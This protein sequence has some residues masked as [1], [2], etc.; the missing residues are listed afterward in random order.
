ML[1]RRAEQDPGLVGEQVLGAVAVM[2]VEVHDGDALDPVG[3]QGVG[4]ADGDIAEETE[5]HRA[6]ALGVVA[7]RPHRAERALDVLPKDEVHRVDECARGAQGRG[8]RVRAHDGVGV[9]A[10]QRRGRRG[11]QQTIDVRCVVD[12]DE[13]LARDLRGLDGA[14]CIRDAGL[15]HV[16]ADRGEP[17]R[18]LGVTGPG[19]VSVAERMREPRACH[20]V[21]SVTQRSARVRSLSPA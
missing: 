14:P 2:H 6:A 9:E 4:R 11:T 7:G 12:S 18:S 8:Q 19:L 5:A 17:F 15:L 16:R 3:F 21:P 13:L 1:E 20:G 10:A